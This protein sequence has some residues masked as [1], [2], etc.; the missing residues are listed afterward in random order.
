MTGGNH[1]CA[2]QEQFYW[3]REKN[4]T[5]MGSRENGRGENNL[6]SVDRLCMRG[7]EDAGTRAD[8]CRGKS[9]STR[10]K[11]RFSAEVIGAQAVHSLQQE[12]GRVSGFQ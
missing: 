11:L 8:S 12:G 5:G 7:L 2:C 3:S 6:T 10:R 1:W 9:L 4:L